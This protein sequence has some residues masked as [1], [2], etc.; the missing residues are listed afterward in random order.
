MSVTSCRE[1]KGRSGELGIKNEFTATRLLQVEVDDP[2]DDEQ[3]VIEYVIANVVAIGTAHPTCAY[4][5]CRNINAV[6]SADD[7]LSWT[8][9]CSYGPFDEDERDENPLS[10]PAQIEYDF[11]VEQVGIDADRDGQ[12]IQNSCGDPFQQAIEVP[13]YRQVINVT[14][15]MA[16]Y[17]AGLYAAYA[18][19]VN[20]D[21]W[22]GFEPGQVQFIP[23]RARREFDPKYGYYYIVD[24][25]FVVNTD[26]YLPLRLLDQ[27]YRQL[28]DDD[29]PV[30]LV[31]AEDEKLSDPALLNGN[32]RKLEPDEPPV[33]LEFQ[34]LNQLP[35]RGVFAV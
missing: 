27:G 5:W 7:G 4:A 26:G 15:H 31:D 6:Q 30:Y 9:T 35:F 18:G 24:W 3:T 29:E 19:A 32:G 12:R 11:Q 2:A 28:N 21:R 20:A 14:K 22:Q 33:F 25:Q 17:N 10:K 1:I 23:G 13:I 8:V 16:T 34:H